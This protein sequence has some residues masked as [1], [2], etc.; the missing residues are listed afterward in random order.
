MDFK[1]FKWYK[2]L[3]IQNFPILT[4]SDTHILANFQY[5]Y[6]IFGLYTNINKYIMLEIDSI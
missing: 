3:E 6:T 5:F 1:Q 2:F 4:P